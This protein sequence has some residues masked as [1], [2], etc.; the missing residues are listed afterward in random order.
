MVRALWVSGSY[1]RQI[2]PEMGRFSQDAMPS[3]TEQEGAK[4]KSIE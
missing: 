2:A 4:S 3:N 1:Q